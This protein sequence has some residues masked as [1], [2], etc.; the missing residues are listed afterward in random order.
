MKRLIPAALIALM[1][2][3]AIA[4][5]TP[6]AAVP[7]PAAVTVPAPD[8]GA[9]GDVVTPPADAATT[10]PPMNTADV[11]APNADTAGEATLTR[12]WEVVDKD[13]SIKF[14]GT[15]M[16]AP[17][18]GTV[19]KFTPVIYFDPDHLDQSHVTV[20]IDILSIDAQDTERNKNLLGSDW[21]DAPQF[22][23]ARFETTKFTKTGDNAY[24]ADATLTIHG[25]AVPVQLPFTLDLAKS[26]S[27]KE[28]AVMNGKI[29]LD[30]SK[31]A[32]GQG[33][34]ADPGVIANEVPVEIKIVATSDAAPKAEENKNAA[35][36]PAKP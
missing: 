21:F 25:N 12:K 17:F 26:D 7:S 20:T 22:P 2:L 30:R 3:Q 34:W 11:P 13:S 33:D 24:T 29:T 23:T 19:D 15:Q 28:K 4:A 35:P 27:G 14:H 6:A 9:P 18:D 32:L 36:A 5:D 8:A 31:F 1:P 10:T 16:N